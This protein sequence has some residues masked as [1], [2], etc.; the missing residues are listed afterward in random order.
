MER[1][2]LYEELTKTEKAEIEKMIN[3][4]LKDFLKGKELKDI[5][6]DIVKKEIK[7]NKDIESNMVDVVQRVLTN[8][9]KTLWTRRSFWLNKLDS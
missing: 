6:I 7:N 1:K 3:R 4:E 8:F 5:V 9:Y 2:L